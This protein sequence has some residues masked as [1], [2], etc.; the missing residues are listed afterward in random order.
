MTAK[1]M[2]TVRV[3]SARSQSCSRIVASSPLESPNRA[4][5]YQFLFALGAGLCSAVRA[6]RW[7]YE[8]CVF[9]FEFMRTVH[10]Q[11]GAV[12]SNLAHGLFVFAFSLQ[13]GAR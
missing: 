9:G 7:F 6:R 11:L 1:A 12:L 8:R 3:R 4:I 10:Y 5:G 2:V 13:A